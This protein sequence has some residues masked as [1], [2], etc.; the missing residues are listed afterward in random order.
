MD[1]RQTC[2]FSFEDAL[3]MQ[4]KSRLKIILD[5][6]D[7]APVIG[8]LS[9]SVS[10][11]GPKSYPVN[12]MLNA[13]VTMRIENIN[14]FSKLVERLNNDPQ[15]RYICGFEPFGD[16]PSISTFSRFYSRLADANCLELLFSSL[17]E[18]ADQM[19]LLDTSSI[20][21]DAT[22]LN[23]Y[24]KAI[25]RKKIVQNGYSA[26]WG[27][28]SDTN[29][30]PIKWFGHKLHVAVDVKSEL[31][32]AI[33]LTPASRADVE[34]ATKL[35]KKGVPKLNE[36]P[37]YF[38]MDSGYDSLYIYTILR[39]QYHAQA[40]IPLNN[41]G[42]KQ[43]K[44]GFDWNGTPVCSAGFPMTYWGY[45]NGVN[46]FRCPHITGKSNCP[47]GSAWC[48]NSNYGMVIKT[49]IKDDPR[50]FCTPHRGTTNWN[51]LYDKRTSSERCFSRLKENLGLETGL[52]L[53]GHKKVLT[54]AYLCCITMIAAVIAVNIASNTEKVAA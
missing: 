30:N 4:P 15:L 48:S 24:E 20:A 38:L 6:L 5:T 17:V 35:I 42:A 45:S 28:K 7:F 51:K 41:R 16:V 13:L 34:E 54:H 33:S 18:Q 21:I 19:G 26:D 22:K 14:S 1:I 12:A 10:Q 2:I 29:G 52:R 32:L 31:P 8:K 39:Y 25:P 36:K 9:H 27:I 23:A 43:P 46:K 47:F 37:C 3:K 11:K 50:L 53:K 44:A 40:I 49:R